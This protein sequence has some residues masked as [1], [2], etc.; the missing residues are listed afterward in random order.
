MMAEKARLFLDHD[1]AERIMASPDPR[2]H[3]RLGRGVHNLDCATWDRVREA[4]VLAG[5]IAKFT[6]NPVMKQHLLSTGNK[7]LAE[8]SPFDLMW[9]IGLR[10]DDP[11]AKDP[12]R[13][14]DKNLPGKSSFRRSRHPPLK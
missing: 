6:Q 11:E 13:W 1:R 14:R 2:E 8:A 10:A 5:S 9:G 3:K 4:A 7:L 12:S